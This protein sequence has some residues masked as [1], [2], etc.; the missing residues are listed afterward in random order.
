[1]QDSD[2]PPT[3]QVMA[4]FAETQKQKEKLMKKW[5]ELKK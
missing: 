3:A 2:R 5:M 4:A 1:L